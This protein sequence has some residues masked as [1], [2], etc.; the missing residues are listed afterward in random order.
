MTDIFQ[1]PNNLIPTAFEET[2]KQK[3]YC[4]Q[5]EE[6]FQTEKVISLYGSDRIAVLDVAAQYAKK[7]KEGRKYTTT[8]N[9]TLKD[10]LLCL[11]FDEFCFIPQTHM[12]EKD[13]R[14]ERYQ[15]IKAILQENFGD[16]GLLVID[17]Y[18]ADT[19]DCIKLEE[20]NVKALIV[21]PH[22]IDGCSCLHIINDSSKVP[23]LPVSK[24]SDAARRALAICFLC[25]SMKPLRFCS[26]VDHETF[27]AMQELLDAGYLVQEN[28]DV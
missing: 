1:L 10:T 27:F 23:D 15:Q 9:G 18:E 28:D 7:V 11:P 17:A 14:N 5:I 4:Q 26:Y 6:I 24:L 21:T 22:P 25:E 2:Q 3:G 19:V 20:L 8:W 13:I 16:D 12:R